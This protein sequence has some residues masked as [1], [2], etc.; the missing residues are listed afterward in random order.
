MA[1]HQK[2]MLAFIN[3][4]VIKTVQFL[5]NF[6]NECETKLINYEMKMQTIEASLKILETK[7]ST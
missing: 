5:N 3:H 7:V 6:A 1:L 4:F 2:R